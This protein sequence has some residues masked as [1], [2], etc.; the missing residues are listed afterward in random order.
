MS[1][2]NER[3]MKEPWCSMCGAF[4]HETSSHFAP[5]TKEKL[6]ELEERLDLLRGAVEVL[7]ERLRRAGIP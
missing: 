5:S 2:D 6:A 3:V 7:A 1:N 4:G